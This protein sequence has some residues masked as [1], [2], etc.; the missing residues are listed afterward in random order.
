MIRHIVI[1]KLK[2][3]DPDIR[4]R[5][6][7]QIKV[8]LEALVKCD[9]GIA[10]IDVYKGEGLVP[11]HWEVILVGDYETQAAL[12]AYQVHPDHQAFVAWVADVMEDRVA[13]DFLV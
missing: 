3:T 12:D 1:F 6:F 2:A 4:E 10:R 13:I 7:Q 8:R 5:D 11:W 9:P